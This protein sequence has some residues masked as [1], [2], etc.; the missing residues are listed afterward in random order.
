MIRRPTA[1]LFF[2][3]GAWLLSASPA[4]A[5]CVDE[6]LVV[7]EIRDD[8]QIALRATNQQSFPITYSV[9]VRSGALGEGRGKRFRGTLDGGESKQVLAVPG[10]ADASIDEFRVSCSWTIGDNNAVH[11]DE[12]LY[13]LP[14]AN[15]H[16]KV[17]GVLLDA[18]MTEARAE[19]LQDAIARAVGIG[20]TVQVFVV[21]DH[22]R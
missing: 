10:L 4:A 18:A 14:Y 12:Y 5:K 19:A 13:R 17:D 8:N 11:D 2:L 6:W 1:Q 20:K 15:G 7:N 21:V 9:R 3:A 16:L 22:R